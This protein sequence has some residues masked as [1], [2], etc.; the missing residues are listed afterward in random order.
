M[1]RAVTALPQGYTQF[2]HINLQTD[3][4]T[5][6]AV[7]LAASVFFVGLLVLGHFAFVPVT[8]LFDID[9]D[10]MTLYLLRLIVLIGGYFAYIVL[11][12]LTHAAAMKLFGATKIR[13]G[14][15]SMP[16]TQAV[17]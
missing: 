16:S 17:R 5:A 2:D 3:K 15:F 8:T 4:K 10:G 7:N 13:F 12:E 6:L 9:A 1:N 14:F 11:H